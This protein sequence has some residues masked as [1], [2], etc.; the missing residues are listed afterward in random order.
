[1]CAAFQ[2]QPEKKTE[3]YTH[4]ISHTNRTQLCGASTFVRQEEGFT[5]LAE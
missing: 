3:Y 1:M 4:C 5:E 2:S